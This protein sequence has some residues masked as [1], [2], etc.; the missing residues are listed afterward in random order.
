[1]S[2]IEVTKKDLA[3][4]RE[5]VEELLSKYSQ[6]ID[7]Y[8]FDVFKHKIFNPYLAADGSDKI[9]L[10]ETYKSLASDIELDYWDSPGRL[11]ANYITQALCQLENMSDLIS[12]TLK[13]NKSGLSPFDLFRFRIDGECIITS[14]E[15]PERYFQNAK[16]IGGDVHVRAKKLK[17]EAFKGAYMGP[18]KDASGELVHRSSLYIEE[19]CEEI[20]RHALEVVKSKSIHLPNSLKRLGRQSFNDLVVSSKVYYN[21]T[22]SEYV[23][24]LK[25]SGWKKIPKAYRPVFCSDNMVWGGLDLQ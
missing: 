25:N 5:Y 23:E 7:A 13:Y 8:K 12:D 1:M 20:D 3:N 4:H 9:W 6:E 22:S 17:E 16:F 14:D 21:G 18:S 11:A 2:S 15:I 10:E 19:G 24:L